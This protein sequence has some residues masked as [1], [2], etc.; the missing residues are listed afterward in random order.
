MTRAQILVAG[1]EGGGEGGE[2]KEETGTEEEKERR[3]QTNRGKDRER[4]KRGKEG[5][6]YTTNSVFLPVALEPLRH[7]LVLPSVIRV[8]KNLFTHSFN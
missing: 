6:K 2:C 5:G 1:G 8:K 4:G 7:C 3:W